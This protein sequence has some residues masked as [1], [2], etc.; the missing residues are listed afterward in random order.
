MEVRYSDSDKY[1][2]TERATDGQQGDKRETERERRET[3]SQ[4]GDRERV[5]NEQNQ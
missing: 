1:M 3:E 4:T 5:N 2:G